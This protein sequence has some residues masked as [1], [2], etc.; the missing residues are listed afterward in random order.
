[1]KVVS[2]YLLSFLKV[3][4]IFLIFQMTS[5]HSIRLL[6]PENTK[7]SQVLSELDP[8]RKVNQKDF[9]DTIHY[10]L[11]KL[12][13]GEA[14][15]VFTFADSNKD[16][17]IDF[18]EWDAF[19]SFFIFPFEKCDKNGD[20]I[21]D[22]A[23]FEACWKSDERS[24]IVEFKSKYKGKEYES[25]IGIVKTRPKFEINFA[26]YIFVR[27]SLFA[28]QNCHSSSKYIAKAHFT[29]ALK[30]A[31]PHQFQI[32]VSY[33][34]V[35]DTGIKIANDPSLNELDY[36]SYLRVLYFSY[37][38][39]IFS[40]HNS[41]YLEQTRF[42]KAIREDIIP[43]R[44]TEDEI[45]TFYVLITSNPLR[46]ET[47]MNFDTFCFFFNLHRLFV[48]YAKNNAN[49]INMEEMKKLLSDPFLPFQI[50]QAIDV[51]KTNFKPADYL[52]SSL[53]LQKLKMNEND[54]YYSFKSLADPA[55]PTQIS[56]NP[57]S[58]DF[59][60]SIMSGFDKAQWSKKIYYT[61][62]QLSN[63]FIN[64]TSDKRYIVSSSTF[65]DKLP[66]LY[67]TINPVINFR[68]RSTYPLYKTLPREI[69][70]DLLT[71]LMLENFTS[72]V[73]LMTINNNRNMITE[74]QLKVV[75]RD[76]GMDKMSDDLIDIAK[77]GYDSI[78]RRIYDP[79]LSIR[80][81]IVVHTIANEKARDVKLLLKN[82]I[83]KNDRVD[84]KF[85][86]DNKRLKNSPLV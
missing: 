43:N 30:T 14:Q 67:D 85:P 24:K 45:N 82:K 33:D 36:I 58:R 5:S 46:Q 35:Y 59:F 60:F 15:Q 39:N 6:K 49:S 27:K 38:F 21:L 41:S 29:C 53:Y 40:E 74:T 51:S 86:I 72:K 75:M 47:Q 76:Y 1:M 28:W 70:L 66:T 79:F 7:L 9:I 16:E 13:R 42:I 3:L 32:K 8:T 62:F 54:F 12:T 57:E 11:F 77:K 65:L 19:K 69:Y 2:Q 17:A 10:A 50:L 73:N 22:K 55:D 64:L 20:F 18:K 84:R 37:V 61:A 26:D 56:A 52:E 80:T 48:K 4:I 83:T 81:L 25:I 23:E 44:F 31:I 68:Q 34:N 63:I 78:K 71:F